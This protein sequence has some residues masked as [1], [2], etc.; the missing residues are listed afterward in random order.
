M[1][2]R[3][4]ADEITNLDKAAGFEEKTIKNPNG[5][6]YLESPEIP[7]VICEIGPSDRI[8]KLNE[9]NGISYYKHQRYGLW[10]FQTDEEQAA[11]L[12]CSDE[13]W[14]R[15]EDSVAAVKQKIGKK[16]GSVAIKIKEPPQ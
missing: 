8:I 13:Y 6:Y 12:P 7:S 4:I 5:H 9:T 2:S 14:F 15:P 10:P 3:F 16:C 11:W 1:G